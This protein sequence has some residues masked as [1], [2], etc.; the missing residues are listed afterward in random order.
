MKPSLLAYLACPSCRA[1]LTVV[2]DTMSGGEIVSGALRCT[3]CAQE[4]PIDDGLPVFVTTEGDPS[5]EQTTDGFARNWIHFNEVIIAEERLNDDLFRDWIAPVDPAHFHDKA[6]LEV[7]CGMGRW[8]SVASRYAPRDLIGLDYSRAATAAHN[9]T[10]MLPHVHVV[11]ADLFH[12]PFKRVFDHIYSIGVIHHTPDPAGGFDEMAKK[13]VDDGSISCWVYGR[14]GNDWI[15]NYLNPFRTQVSTKLPHSALAALTKVA[16]LG[17]YGASKVYSRL[18]APVLEHLFYADY[19]KHLARYPRKYMEHIV[20]D[21]L[22]PEIAEYV[23][24]EEVERWA[25]KNHLAYR[26][27]QRNGNSWRLFAGPN[28]AA[29]QAMCSN[30]ATAV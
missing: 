12:M 6:V 16:A 10:R 8:L 14:E 2:H 26:I 23:P 5:V 20:Y 25:Q 9:N 3:G 15:I 27:S 7:G 22:V 29:L 1:D 30:P 28:E 13:I 11:R 24:K 18:P 21:H 4:F 19:I 17:L